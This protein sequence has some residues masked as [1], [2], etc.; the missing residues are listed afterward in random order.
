MLEARVPWAPASPSNSWLCPGFHPVSSQ[1]FPTQV[2]TTLPNSPQFTGQRLGRG[3][4]WLL[5][6]PESR[7][8]WRRVGSALGPCEAL[9]L[10]R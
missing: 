3:Q 10:Q 5:Q 4:F 7:Q 9:R 2:R 8:C 6:Q 1:S